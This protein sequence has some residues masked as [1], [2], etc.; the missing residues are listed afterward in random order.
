M[1]TEERNFSLRSAAPLAPLAAAGPP[2][3]SGT[4]RRRCPFSFPFRFRDVRCAGGASDSEALR[5]AGGQPSPAAPRSNFVVVR[6]RR[7]SPEALWRDAVANPGVTECPRE[8][9]PLSAAKAKAK[10][11]S[12]RSPSKKRAEKEKKTCVGRRPPT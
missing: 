11:G 9:S 3:R 5:Q 1:F 4:A 2:S 6:D 8:T 7:L 12:A 10:V